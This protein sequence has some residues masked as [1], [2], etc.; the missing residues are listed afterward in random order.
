MGRFNA[1]WKFPAVAHYPVEHASFRQTTLASGFAPVAK[2]N[3]EQTDL[4]AL[5]DDLGFG[6]GA[7][8]LAG[9]G[10]YSARSCSSEQIRSSAENAKA[11]TV[12]MG[13]PFQPS[14]EELPQ[15]IIFHANPPT[16]S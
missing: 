10:R 14:S 16:L 8:L 4:F 5:G 6:P 15:V 13:Y 12:R 7:A 11:S 3:A 9:F 1:L 2:G